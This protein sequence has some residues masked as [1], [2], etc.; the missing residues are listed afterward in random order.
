VSGTPAELLAQLAAEARSSSPPHDGFR[1]YELA[2]TLQAN[3]KDLRVDLDLLRMLFAG[4][5]H[6]SNAGRVLMRFAGPG[7]AAAELHRI[8]AEGASAQWRGAQDGEVELGLA[9]AAGN[10]ASEDDLRSMYASAV[11]G[12]HTA[13]FESLVSRY[14]VDADELLR[15]SRSD[16]LSQIRSIAFNALVAGIASGRSD[17]PIVTAEVLRVARDHD[18]PIQ[19]QAIHALGAIG[20]EGTKLAVELLSSGAVPDGLVGSLART[21]VSAGRVDDLTN[22]RAAGPA[23]HGVLAVLRQALSDPA[24]RA[25]PAAVARLLRSTP[26]PD[27]A[28]TAE[29]YVELAMAVGA[30]EVPAGVAQRR[31]TPAT[32]RL[33]AASEVLSADPPRPE[34]ERVAVSASILE[35]APVDATRRREF[36]EVHGSELVSLGAAGRALVERIAKNDPDAWVR[37]QAAQ[38]LRDAK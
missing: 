28:E 9:H 13:G 11:Q 10:L 25:D 16:P 37:H 27:D 38:V 5:G 33:N 36:L 8:L 35:G 7:A 18:D 26:V 24:K 19:E 22:V 4:P 14:L 3:A 20:P 2:T 31:E 23:L 17:L 32:V 30:V 34:S 12:V 29:L 6:M 21:V 15:L 1:A